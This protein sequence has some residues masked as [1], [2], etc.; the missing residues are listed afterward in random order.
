MNKTE[1]PLSGKKA[2]DEERRRERR[3]EF[4]QYV[5]SSLRSYNHYPTCE[6]SEDPEVQEFLRRAVIKF[7]VYFDYSKL[8]YNGDK[9]AEIIIGCPVHGDIRM[10]M[11]EHINTGCPLC[12]EEIRRETE[13]KIRQLMKEKI[14]ASRITLCRQ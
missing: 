5:R 8:R 2:E 10:T 6:E 14:N 11:R 7:N 3:E 4:Q 9:K 1:E 13:E 12:R